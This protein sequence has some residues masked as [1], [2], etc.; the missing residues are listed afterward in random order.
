MKLSFDTIKS[1]TVGAVRIWEKDE[2]I[3]FSKMTEG[4]ISAYKALSDTLFGTASSTTGIRFDFH[5]DS[6]YVKFVCANAGKYEVKIDGVLKERIMA[7]SGVEYTVLL[8]TDASSHRVTLHLPSHGRGAIQSLEIEDGKS[9]KRHV[10][11]TKMLFIGDSITQGWNSHFDTLSYAY[12]VSDHFNAESIIQGAGGAYYHR[13]TLEKLDFEPDT[14]FVA[15]GTNDSFRVREM[16]DFASLV[17]DCLS[18]VKD[19]YPY[20]KIYVITPIWRTDYNEPKPYG[21]VKAIADCIEEEAHKLSLEVIC[22]MDMIPPFD[23]FM[24]D[25]LHPNDL[26]FSIYAHNLIKYLT[27]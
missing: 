11:D 27:K 17:Y 19:F 3:H 2:C 7:E 8:P 24:D 22:G 10:F 5:T 15:Y 26:G 16:P 23:N 1:I 20:A 9:L 25:S 6:S 18:M 12:Q 21:H 14:V 13:T 4:Q